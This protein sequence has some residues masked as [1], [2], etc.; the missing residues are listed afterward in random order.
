MQLLLYRQPIA[1]H[2][3]RK[4]PSRG[5]IWKN[6]IQQLK[7]FWS[8]LHCVIIASFKFAMAS[9]FFFFFFFFLIRGK[10]LNSP[11]MMGKGGDLAK[12]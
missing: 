2:E 4:L 5:S 12:Y 7:S 11:E 8:V 6:A 10:G 3:M 9:L 1:S